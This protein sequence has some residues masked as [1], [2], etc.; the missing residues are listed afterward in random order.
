L[1]TF[2]GNKTAQS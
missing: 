1:T 2:N